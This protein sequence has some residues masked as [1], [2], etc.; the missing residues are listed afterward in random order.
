M[1]TQTTQTAPIQTQAQAP[2]QTREAPAGKPS[3]AITSQAITET[4]INPNRPDFAKDAQ[5]KYLSSSEYLEG[6]AVP[7]QGEAETNQEGNE[8]ITD[9]PGSEGN[10]NGQDAEHGDQDQQ[11]SQSTKAENRTRRVADYLNQLAREKAELR[12]MKQEIDEKKKTTP[13]FDI[14][15]LKEQAKEDP[16]N[17]LEQLG[18]NYNDLTKTILTGKDS[19]EKRLLKKAL[20]DV[21]NLKKE[22]HEKEAARQRQELDYQ[23]E[24]SKTKLREHIQ[25]HGDKYEFINATN[26][27]ET[28]FEVIRQYWDYTTQQGQPKILSFDEAAD[29]VESELEKS[30]RTRIE[31]ILKTN[32]AR[33]WN[34]QSQSTNEPTQEFVEGSQDQNSQVSPSTVGETYVKKAVTPQTPKTITGQMVSTSVGRPKRRLTR[35]ESIAEAAKLLRFNT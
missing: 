23:M 2:V 10:S 9:S 5:R 30:E 33:G 4:V 35:D 25:S 21:E 17:T 1:D 6:D 24:S 15:S 3:Q 31:S 34:L 11:Q 18:L 12:K 7:E 14:E 19:E 13:A 22:I 27:Y 29:I 16:F 26:N 28:V 20:D 8:E 32:K